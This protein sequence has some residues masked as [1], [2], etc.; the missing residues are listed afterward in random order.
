MKKMTNFWTWFQDNQITIKN[1]LN[2]SPKKQ[3][4]IRYWIK[5][6]LHYYCI[7]IDFILVF[8]N[9]NNNSE[10]IITAN[11][12]PIYFKQVIALVDSAPILKTWKFKAFISTNETIEKRLNKLDLHYII[13]EIKLK[14]NLSEYIPINLENQSKKQTIHIHLKNY[15]IRC[16]NKTFKQ[17]IYYIL[18]EILVTTILYENISFVQLAYPSDSEQTKYIQ[19]NNKE[20]IYLYEFQIFINII[21]C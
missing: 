14:D 11:G 7:D 2:E 10:L 3:E 13:P 4:S 12:N 17:A 8:P 9:N 1:I 18:V 15:A 5:Q 19:G 6:N 21:K 20:L 16:S